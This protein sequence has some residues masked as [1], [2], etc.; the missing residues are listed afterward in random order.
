MQ[1]EDPPLLYEVSEAQR[2]I[3]VGKTKFNELVSSGELEVVR[4]GRVRRVPA[5]ALTRYVER[6]RQGV[7]TTNQAPT[8][9][10]PDLHQRTAKAKPA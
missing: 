3:R 5:D 7:T 9:S 4:I 10:S 8:P 1:T 2:K 6:L